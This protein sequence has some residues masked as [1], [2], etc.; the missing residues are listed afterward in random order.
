MDVRH[1]C[2]G[3]EDEEVYPVF[4][5][6]KLFADKTRPA[7]T[8]ESLFWTPVSIEQLCTSFSIGLLTIICNRSSAAYYCVAFVRTAMIFD[9][10]CS[11]LRHS[12]TRFENMFCFRFFKT[13][14]TRP[15]ENLEQRNLRS[16][17]A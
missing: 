7:K 15:S 17:H 9:L 8:R 5:C 10:P 13:C 16:V 2:S 12:F 11:F 3:D 4:V 6:G 14:Y 1:G